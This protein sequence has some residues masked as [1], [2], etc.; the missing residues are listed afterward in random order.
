[1]WERSGGRPVEFPVEGRRPITIGRD[2]TSTIVLPST[3][4]SRAHA[5]FQ[6]QDGKFLIEDLGSANGT[7]VNGAP[8]AV[9]V[10]VPG[11][12]IEIG[13]ERLVFR[14]GAARPS[15]PQAAP[16]GGQRKGLRLALVAAITALG[17]TAV[18][19]FMLQPEPSLTPAPDAQSPA[20]PAGGV[21]SG[22]AGAG[23]PGSTGTPVAAGAPAGGPAPAAVTRGE[24]ESVKQV[25][26]E[27]QI[28]GV[29]PVDALYDRG[30]LQYQAGRF[31]DAADLFAAV[32]ARDKNHEAAPRMLRDAQG[33]IERG[34]AERLA[35][36]DSLFTQLRFEEAILQWE[37]VLQ[38][39]DSADLRAAAARSG[40][41]RARKARAAR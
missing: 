32:V 31:R 18:M 26:R 30:V 22:P 23:A 13:E 36:A 41:D 21:G 8:V 9:S 2:A 1:V 28:A 34:V 5:R 35:R 15:G 40:I 27:A 16:A 24:S 11:D 25:L 29:K 38:M 14:D 19:M 12:T 20:A 39:V 17:M 3:F 6:Y 33:R 37:E 7:R 4:V 10:V